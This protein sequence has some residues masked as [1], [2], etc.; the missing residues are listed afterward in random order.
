MTIDRYALHGAALFWVWHTRDLSS[1]GQ[2]FPLTRFYK[3][4]TYSSCGTI[5]ISSLVRRFRRLMN[6][7]GRA[8]FRP[9]IETARR[10]G[11]LMVLLGMYQVGQISF[12][13][14][15]IPRR[16]NLDCWALLP[17]SGSCL[18]RQR[19]KEPSWGLER[20]ALYP[21]YDCLERHAARDP[22]HWQLRCPYTSI[23]ASA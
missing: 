9:S 22:Y 8:I 19:L 10:N 15:W 7:I 11:V 4:S 5:V 6:E 18:R 13:L 14:Q 1:L 20:V 17:W 21:R 12:H 16:R 2:Q 23:R 3:P